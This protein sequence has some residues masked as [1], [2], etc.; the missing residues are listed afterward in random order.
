MDIFKEEAINWKE[1]ILTFNGVDS[2]GYYA[3]AILALA[4]ARNGMRKFKMAAEKLP[5]F[6]EKCHRAAGAQ[7]GAALALG[8][9]AALG[10]AA[11]PPP[12]AAQE[13]FG[14]E[15]LSTEGGPGLP[16]RGSARGVSEGPTAT[17]SGASMCSLRRQV[18]GQSSW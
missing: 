14:A 12:P 18:V 17:L 3:S 10:G 5:Q 1:M 6:P 9:A 16:A 11:A 7:V 15:G 8:A 13:G 4:V 2:H